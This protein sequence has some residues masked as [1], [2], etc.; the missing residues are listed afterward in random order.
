MQMVVT[1]EAAKTARLLNPFVDFATICLELQLKAWQA[2]QVEGTAFV[3]R[4]MHADLEHLRKLGHCCEAGSVATCQLA[5][6]RDIQKDY[7]EEWGRLSAT[8]FALGFS[9]LARLGSL[10]GPRPAKVVAEARSERVAQPR[11]GAS[12]MPNL[13]PVA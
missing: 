3:A 7:A 8:T 11:A 12:P 13:R 5:W 10:F 6:L 4:R 1:R 9:D 2:Y